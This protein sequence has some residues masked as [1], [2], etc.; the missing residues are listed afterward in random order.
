MVYPSGVIY[1]VFRTQD[2][3]LRNAAAYIKRVRAKP[4]TV[5]STHTAVNLAHIIKTHTPLSHSDC[6][7]FQLPTENCRWFD[8]ETGA[9]TAFT[10]KDEKA[11]YMVELR[12]VHDAVVMHHHD[13]EKSLLAAKTSSSF[14]GVFDRAED[15][16]KH[17]DYISMLPLLYFEPP[18]G[19]HVLNVVP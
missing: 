14:Y 7:A 1:G 2:L 16:D 18:F 15:W 12:R 9:L 19:G 10:L 8:N 11:R 3:L 17:R 6:V 13:I 4:M 5:K